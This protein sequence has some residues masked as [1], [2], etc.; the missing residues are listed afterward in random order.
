M[1]DHHSMAKPI[2]LRVCVRVH[3]YFR[4][5][6]ITAQKYHSTFY[7][8]TLVVDFVVVICELI[9]F[10]L[11]IFPNS[12]AIGACWI[13]KKLNKKSAATIT[14]IHTNTHAHNYKPYKWFIKIGLILLFLFTNSFPIHW[15]LVCMCVCDVH[16][17]NAIKINRNI[18][19]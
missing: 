11:L 17:R 15:S 5:M 1:A 9:F 14:S 16:L 4:S 19:T 2:H 12:R 7:L 6:Q 10:A 3:M 18:Y 13:F 8:W